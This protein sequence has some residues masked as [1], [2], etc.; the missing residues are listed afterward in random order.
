[1][2]KILICSSN[3][4][5]LDSF[6]D[7]DFLKKISGTYKI[8]FL[9]GKLNKK[10]L[11]RISFLKKYGDIFESSEINK[12]SLK[13]SFRQ[14]IN[15][16]CYFGN[17]ILK[18]KERFKN[19]FLIKRTLEVNAP[20][21]IKI[22]EFF[23]KT[24]LLSFCV[25]S[26]SFFLRWNVINIFKGQDINNYDIVLVAFKIYDPTSFTDELLRY[27]KKK[28]TTTYGIQ[29]NW[30]AL[31]FRIPLEKPD[32]LAVWGEQSFSFS[33]GLHKIS[34][35]KIF[36][37]GPLA[38]DIY[39]NN[40]INQ[41]SARKNLNLPE[42]GK[43]IA[44]CLSDIVFDDIFIVKKINEL[45]K[46]SFFSKDTYFYFKGYRFGK[47]LTLKKSYELEY[48]LD[49]EDL[50]THQNIF[51]WEPDSLNMEKRDYFRNFFKAVDGIISTFSTMSVEA[52][53][54]N[55]PSIA[56]H[57]NPSDYK[58]N[59]Y[60]FP[61]KFYSYHLYS[62][63]NQKGLIYCNSREELGDKIKDLLNNNNK[64]LYKIPLTSVYYDEESASDKI[65]KSIEVIL[66]KGKRDKSDLGYK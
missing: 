49:Y 6:F 30:D 39:K 1:M 44:I 40:N 45:L 14:K 60:G 53:L 63:R 10:D 62:L 65:K 38:F 59:T 3:I 54:H 4:T 15:L 26:L 47:N 31:V 27:C 42:N 50:N 52:L 34:P 56:L 20:H 16:F 22:F 29:I 9:I 35:Y 12:N 21:L 32:F 18:N 24:K 8:N 11:K 7:S 25:Y 58:V 5:Q 48:N 37:T 51:F 41:K 2:K 23:Y 64:N 57:Y 17:E 46:N 43:I 13:N 61:F 28:N 36:P 55:L 66:T 33:V 19:D